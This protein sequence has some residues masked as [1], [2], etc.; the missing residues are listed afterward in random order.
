MKKLITSFA[1]ITIALYTTAQCHIDDWTGLKALYESTNGDNWDD[2]EG[3]DILI[4]NQ[5]S[6]PANCNLEELAGIR[7]DDDGRVRS[8]S[9]GR[10]RL[11]GTIP[12][13]IGNIKN[14]SFIDLA[15]NN[16]TG[17]IP[18]AFGNLTSLTEVFLNACD[19]TGNLPAEI[20]NLTNLVDLFLSQNELTGSIPVEFGNL[21]KI[22]QIVL[23]CNELT[24]SI[25]VEL[26]NL[27]KLQ[28]LHLEDNQLTGSIPVELGNAPNLRWIYLNKNQLTGSIPPE[29]GNLSVLNNLHLNGNQLSGSIPSELGNFSNLEELYLNDNELTGGIPAEFVNLTDMEKLNLSNNQLS[30]CYSDSLTFFCND[31][32]NAEI[33]DGN[34][35]DTAWEDFCSNEGACPLVSTN[36]Y[37]LNEAINFVYNHSSQTLNITSSNFPVE[38]VASYN[39]NGQLSKEYK[40]NPSVNIKIDVADLPVGLYVMVA[41]V[42]EKVFQT[43]LVV[44]K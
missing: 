6:P 18:A 34:N 39:S 17:N 2:W 33:S 44:Q 14:L 25:P 31:F 36:S 11:N 32:S 35:F 3:W 1:F 8:L 20:G 12:K 42:E 27:P 4:A 30:G 13:E 28:N 40:I 9:L 38:Y 23:D 5:I 10:N 24:G 22:Y 16:L 29:L 37:P 15:G 41:T 7:L 26:G 43:K 19:F 21:T